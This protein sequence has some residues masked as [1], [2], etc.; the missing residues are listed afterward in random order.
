M[1]RTLDRWTVLPYGRLTQVEENIL[2]VVGD[3]RM[4]LAHF[5]RR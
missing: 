3:L 4:P 2:T 1:P 5:L